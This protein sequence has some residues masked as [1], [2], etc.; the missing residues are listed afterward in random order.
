V[1]KFVRM[2]ESIP[3]NSTSIRATRNEYSLL[4]ARRSQS[5]SNLQDLHQSSTICAATTNI[6]SVAQSS[7]NAMLVLGTVPGIS[8]ALALPSS[9]L[10]IDEM[11]DPICQ[12][13]TLNRPRKGSCYKCHSK[14]WVK[15]GP[16]PA[17]NIPR[18]RPPTASV[19][20]DNK[21]H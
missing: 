6:A 11:K 19:H 4:N 2:V 1:R 20:S 9:H 15:A 18:R 7:F 12:P 14:G 13:L 10:F 3:V 17:C 8:P 16:C 21:R 5:S